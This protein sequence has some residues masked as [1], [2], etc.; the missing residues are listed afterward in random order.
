[1][2][3]SSCERADLRSRA[4]SLKP[5]AQIGKEG[6][7]EAAVAGVRQAFN[8]RDLVKVKVLEMAPEGPRETAQ[9][10]AAQIDGAEVVQ[11]MGR[12]LTLH[13]PQPEGTARGSKPPAGPPGGA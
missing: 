9:A 2:P 1:M 12:T 5:V 10:L 6:L 4:H 3:L 7:T 11:V 13:R 8:T